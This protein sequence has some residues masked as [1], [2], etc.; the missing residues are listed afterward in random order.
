MSLQTTGRILPELFRQGLLR[1]RFPQANIPSTTQISPVEALNHSQPQF[2]AA[3]D[4]A[5]HDM[6][7][8]PP[9]PISKKSTAIPS[10]DAPNNYDDDRASIASSQDQYETPQNLGDILNSADSDSGIDAGDTSNT[11]FES[12]PTS[13]MPETSSQVFDLASSYTGTF[14]SSSSISPSKSTPSSVSRAP[15]GKSLEQSPHHL[16][17]LINDSERHCMQLIED[18][19]KMQT[20]LNEAIIETLTCKRDIAKLQ[21][22]RGNLSRALDDARQEIARL[23]KKVHYCDKEHLF[24]N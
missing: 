3:M 2:P 15:Q 20:N 21:L 10:P 12:S 24:F 8:D 16:M 19:S 4:L 6:Y 22:E 13:V 17:R 1:V 11:D 9:S 18:R 5:T 14:D 23:R 7:H